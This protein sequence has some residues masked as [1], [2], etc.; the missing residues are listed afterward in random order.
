[1]KTAGKTINASHGARTMSAAVTPPSASVASS[2]AFSDHEPMRADG[3]FLPVLTKIAVATSTA[4]MTGYAAMA[5][6]NASSADAV[7]ELALSRRP[8]APSIAETAM[9]VTTTPAAL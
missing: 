9:H 4:L 5:T 2:R 6:T 7:A 8:K 3:R 1:M